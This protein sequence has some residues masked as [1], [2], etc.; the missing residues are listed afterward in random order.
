MRIDSSGNLLVGTTTHR[1]FSGG[2]TE[3]TV[4]TASTGATAGGAITFGSGSG[5]LGYLGFQESEG[6]LGTLTSV[7]L[8]FKTGNTERMRLDA[9]GN[10]L[11]GKSA[12]SF[13]TA[14]VELNQG[15]TAGKVQ[16]QRSSSP[17]AW[18]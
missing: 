15:G 14:G 6:T 8:V 17:L 7:P 4:G 11:V 1:D 12:S 18:Y 9:S 10:L 3:I 5:F 2:T 16:I 13:T